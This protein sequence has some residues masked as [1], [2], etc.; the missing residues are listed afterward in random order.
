[1]RTL[2]LSESSKEMRSWCK[3][4]TEAAYV[5][6][7]SNHRVTKMSPYEAVFGF[8][9][10]CEK[11]EHITDAEDKAQEAAAT[12]EHEVGLE[13]RQPKQQRIEQNHQKYNMT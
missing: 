4:T 5:R 3:Y 7:I 1:M 10:H 12:S 2:I 11:L 6:N 13:E 9:P 8:K